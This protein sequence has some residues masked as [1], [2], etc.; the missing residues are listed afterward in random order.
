M[1]VFEESAEAFQYAQATTPT[2]RQSRER[3]NCFVDIPQPY[4]SVV[5]NI[6]SPPRKL[7]SR[8]LALFSLA[9]ISVALIVYAGTMIRMSNS[10]DYAPILTAILG[11]WLGIL[12]SHRLD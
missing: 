6:S 8:M 2:P 3:A 9:L 7:T 5:Q 12:L 4:E 11:L 1:N 10:C